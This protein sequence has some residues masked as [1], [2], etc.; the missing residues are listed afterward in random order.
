ME[1]S[2]IMQRRPRAA[3]GAAQRVDLPTE[4]RDGLAAALLPPLQRWLS[5]VRGVEQLH[6]LSG[7][8]NQ[9]TWAFEA[10]VGEVRVPLVLRRAAKRADRTDSESEVARQHGPV[11]TL[12]TEAALIGAAQAAGLP[13]PAVLGVLAPGD[14]LGDGFVMSRIEGETIPRKIL[15]EPEFDAV[16][17]RLAFECGQILARLHRIPLPGLPALRRSPARAERAYDLARHRRLGHPKP[18]VE[19]ALR[20]ARQHAPGE[21]LPLTFV[22]GDFRHGNLMIGRERINA[23]LDWELAHLGDPMEDLGWICV[24]SWRFGQIALPVGGF[25]TREQLFAGYASEGGEVDPARA[26]YWK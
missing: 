12:A 5:D 24:N 17:P 18:V 1:T 3:D 16:R 6:R 21:D 4:D 25:G 9:Q 15:R 23:V 11:M 26:H 7:G 10:Q 8:A 20:L 19:L 2:S 22:H 14:G 13:V